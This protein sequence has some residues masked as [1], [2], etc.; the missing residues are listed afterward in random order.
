MR[1]AIALVAVAMAGAAGA[2]EHHHPGGEGA[3]QWVADPW[4]VTVHGFANAVIDHQGGPRG[5]DETFSNSMLMAMAARPAAQGILEL[6]GMLSLDPLMGRDGY[7]L[8]FQTG[9][10]A[11]GIT[12]LVDRQHPHDFFMQLAGQYTRPIGERAA[13]FV[14]A[15]LPG[16]PALGP[17]AFMH[18]ASG[19]RIPEAPLT[20]HWLDSTHIT[21]GVLT[22]GYRYGPWTLEASR[23]NGREPD[24]NRWNIE[25]GSL[26]SSS[27]RITY[28]P[29]PGLSMQV[30]YGF[31]KD[32]EEVQRNVSIH[33]ATASVIWETQAFG[34]PWATTLAWGQNDKVDR[35]QRHD[36]PGW[37]F[38]TTLEPVAGLTTF[39]RAERFKHDEFSLVLPF[40]KVSAGVIADTGRTG[41]VKWGLGALVSYLRPPQELLFFYGDHPTAWML[42]LQARL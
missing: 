33:R 31:L 29:M 12:H 7:P 17:P 5:A 34:R 25:T 19:E 11:N 38:E 1:I 27:G 4:T 26:D 20:H 41:P 13:W 36:L 15:G 2:Q 39:V 6:T 28:A 24:E 3:L 21:F 14:Y 18:R 22:A 9:E 8:L 10:T 32:V 35:H 30:S 23:F 37:L 16:E 40:G 42:F